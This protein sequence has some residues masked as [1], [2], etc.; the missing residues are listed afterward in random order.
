MRACASCAGWITWRRIMAAT[1]LTKGPFRSLQCPT[2]S[3]AQRE[4]RANTWKVKAGEA[5]ALLNGEM[6][7]RT[8]R[9]RG[10]QFS[11]HRCKKGLCRTEEVILHR[12]CRG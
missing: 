2:C 7:T 6:V 4:I 11:S 12:A 10:L 8:G 5:Q 1:P 3:L 9:A